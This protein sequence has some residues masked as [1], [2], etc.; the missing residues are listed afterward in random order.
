MA[1]SLL[2]PLIQL[3][4][5]LVRPNVV[6]DTFHSVAGTLEN[7]GSH[8]QAHHDGRMQCNP[9]SEV[10]HCEVELLSNQLPVWA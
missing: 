9:E 6:E 5:L 2:E 8:G 7:Y 4:V 10:E 3:L 1:E